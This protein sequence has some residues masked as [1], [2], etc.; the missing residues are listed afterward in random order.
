MKIACCVSDDKSYQQLEAWFGRARFQ[1]ERF[2]SEQALLRSLRHRSAD[3]IVFE[4]KHL[5]PDSDGFFSWLSCRSG[6]TV[7]VLLLSHDASPAFIAT[8]LDAGA[9]DVMPLPFDSG[10]LMAR[11]RA[12][13]RR[14]SRAPAQRT[15]E[16]AGFVLDRE[17]STLR[18][19][20]APIELTPREF[21]MAWLFFSTPGVFIA[22]ETISVA[23][24]GVGS[25]VASRTIEQH[26]YKLR[27][28]LQLGPER[29]VILRT[30]YTQGYRLEFSQSK[31]GADD[32]S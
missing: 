10:E 9:D 13:L 22:R 15:V 6:E 29:G 7:P 16:Q 8:V 12:L 30:A 18:D 25:E 5:L 21:T 1:C 26:V 11:V 20:G 19:R 31:D 3:L 28:K 17:A 32:L 4:V 14:S 27:K 24:W 2:A 23:I